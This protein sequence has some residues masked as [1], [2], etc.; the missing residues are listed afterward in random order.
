MSDGVDSTSLFFSSTQPDTGLYSSLAAFTLSRAPHSSETVYF[1]SY[2]NTIISTQGQVL[3]LINNF[4]KIAT[5]L[6]SKDSVFKAAT[7][8]HLMV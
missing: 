4:M 8:R 6:K 3:F 1:T 7:N 5:L 2:V